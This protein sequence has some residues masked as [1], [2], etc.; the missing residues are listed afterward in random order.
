MS[1]IQRC[2]TCRGTK[3]VLS[4]GMMERTCNACLGVGFIKTEP[5]TTDLKDEPKQTE[6]ASKPKPKKKSKPV[7]K[8]KN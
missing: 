2:A 3:K 4:L 8:T 5:E 1:N 6:K 7:D